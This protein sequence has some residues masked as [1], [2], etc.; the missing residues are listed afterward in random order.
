M[1]CRQ[2]GTEIAEKALICFRCGT[3]TTEA[4]YKPHVPA[5]GRA[6]TRSLIGSIITI[7]ALVILA[8]TIDRV[9]PFHQRDL[10]RLVAWLAVVAATL[11]TV[12]AVGRRR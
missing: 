9:V 8:L 7:L 2:C 3:A 11:I 6:S 1:Q 5:R 4:K 10:A 12:R